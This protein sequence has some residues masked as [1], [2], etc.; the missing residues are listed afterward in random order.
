ML[1]LPGK[2]SKKL[3]LNPEPRVRDSVAM[4]CATCI[5]VDPFDTV[6]SLAMVV[7]SGRKDRGLLYQSVP[8]GH[9]SEGTIWSR[10][11]MYSLVTIYDIS[12]D[13]MIPM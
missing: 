7:W 6:V 5:P 2:R 1:F 12:L 9:V 8:S 10:I 4:H 11:R 13:K 3:T